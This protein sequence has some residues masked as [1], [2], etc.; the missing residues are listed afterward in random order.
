[1]VYTILISVV[2][3]AE[4]IITFA[5]IQN[6]IKLDKLILSFDETLNSTKSGL[7][8][9]SVLMRKIS[10]Q[11]IVLAT[12]FIENIKEGSEELFL[13]KFSKALVTLLV[14]N[15]NFKFI[16]S[17]KKSKLTKTLAKGFLLLENM[18]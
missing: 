7:K 13:Q 1:M 8:D 2:F 18:V 4:L 10:E 16:K 15:L 3:V 6:L 17:L 9:I 12:D 11:W 14:I 5:I